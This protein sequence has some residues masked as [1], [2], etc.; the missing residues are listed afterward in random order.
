MVAG[1]M[2]CVTSL[3][4]AIVLK[5]GDRLS[6]HRDQEAETAD[7]RPKLCIAVVQR[8]DGRPVVV[9]MVMQTV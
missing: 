3:L 9:V 4:A 2:D 8:S 5:P 6:A 7:P 1:G